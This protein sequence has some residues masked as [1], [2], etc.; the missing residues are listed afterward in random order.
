MKNAS[1]CG[2]QHSHFTVKKL[3]FTLIELLI[4]IAIIALLAAILFPVFSRA[5]ENA[6]RAS[7]QSNEKQQALGLMQYAQDYDERLPF[8]ASSS[9]ISFWFR[10]IQPYVKSPNIFRCPNAPRTTYDINDIE[11]PTYCLPG[12]DIPSQ[13]KLTILNRDGLHLSQVG[14]PARTF[15]IME[16]KDITN[17][18]TTGEGFSMCRM[19]MVPVNGQPET[20]DYVNST[21]HFDGY[22]VA[23]VDGHVKWI[24]A[25]NGKNWI[26]DLSR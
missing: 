11:Y 7:C 17:Y 2:Y 6:R 8:T 23:F 22:N 25:G 12:R 20:A 9:G 19:T 1:S 26:F 3:G 14:E 4:V 10:D 5:R 15:M 24:K 16:S 13:R 18:F 21:I